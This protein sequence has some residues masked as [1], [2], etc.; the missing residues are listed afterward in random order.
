MGSTIYPIKRAGMHFVTFAKPSMRFLVWETPNEMAYKNLAL[1][2]KEIYEMNGYSRYD[3]SGK[4]VVDV[5]GYYGETAI[6]FMHR[7]AAKVICYEPYISGDLIAINCALNGVTGVTVFRQPV[8]HTAGIFFNPYRKN[9]G[10]M[11]FEPK[12]GGQIGVDPESVTLADIAIQDAVLKMDC[13][14]SEHGIFETASKETLRK[15]SH[16]MM[17]VHGGHEDIVERLTACGFRID[18][19]KPEWAGTETLNAERID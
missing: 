16:I 10:A 5:G 15:F 6:M 3:V 2:L 8:L 11:P 9:F 7:G 17:E 18:S 1:C 12:E 4:T 14:G 19:L 13:E